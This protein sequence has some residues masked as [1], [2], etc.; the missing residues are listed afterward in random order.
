MN[1]HTAAQAEPVTTARG[2]SRLPQ[3]RGRPMVTD[4]G[5]ETG[6]IF[7]HGVDL[8]HFAVFPLLETAVGRALV[9]DYYHGYA[10]I[11][12]RAG[13]GPPTR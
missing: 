10:A 6:L 4:G 7:H 13:A 12:R 9:E 8:P 11:A 1:R 2:A 5:M 3:L